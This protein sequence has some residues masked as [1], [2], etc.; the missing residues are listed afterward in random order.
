MNSDF[1]NT[2]LI[3]ILGPTASGKTALAVDLAYQINGE[4]ISADSRQVYRNMDI[5][6]G[7]DLSEYKR[8]DKD[9]PYHLINICDAGE[10]YNVARFQNDFN[11][12]F[13]QVKSRNSVPILCGGTGL[14]IQ[15]VISDVWE[16]QIPINEGFREE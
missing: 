2:E 12:V 16:T 14:Y 6:T 5:G 3:V 9:V 4:I 15:S 1:K 11:D 10:K 8:K 7:K 13:E